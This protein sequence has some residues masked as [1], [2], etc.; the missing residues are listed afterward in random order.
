MSEP[1]ISQAAHEKASDRYIQACQVLAELVVSQ[2]REIELAAAE[3]A[4]AETALAAQEISPGIPAYLAQ[5]NPWD[6]RPALRVVE[7]RASERVLE[8]MD[9]DQAADYIAQGRADVEG[10]DQA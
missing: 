7:G 3:L 10:S 8:A 2:R 1:T 5:G 9:P 6:A 4:L